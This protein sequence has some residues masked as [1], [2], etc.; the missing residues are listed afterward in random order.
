M[1]FLEKIKEEKLLEVE[2]KKNKV[3]IEKLKKEIKKGNHSFKKA[4]KKKGVSLIAEFKKASPSLGEINREASLKNYVSLYDKYADCISILTDEKYF[5]GKL[6]FLSEAKK[7]TKKPILRKD[8]I[9]DEYQIYESR[10]CNADAVLLIAEMLSK[11][12]IDA[13]LGVCK[14]LGMDALVECHDAKN[15]EKALSSGAEIIG[16]N[17]RNLKTMKEDFE[18][19]ERLLKKIPKAKR[20]KLIIVSESAIDTVG[21]INSLKE[22]ADAVL[23]GSAIMSCA[24]PEIKLKELNGKTL[25]KI[26]GVTN[27]KDAQDAVKL[28]ADMVGL[29]FYEKSPRFVDVKKAKEIADAIKGKALIVGVFVNESPDE[30]NKI[31]KNVS[32]DVLQFSGK[33]FPGYAR[34]FSLPIIKAIHIKDKNS[35][36]AAKNYH[37]PMILV[38]A[39]QK[40]LYG[41]TGK[42]INPKMIDVSKI[43]NKALVFSGGLNDKNVAGIVKKFRPFM[44]DTAS[45]VESEAGKK[46]FSKMKSF[47]S[48]VRGLNK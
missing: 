41:G 28:G 21:K 26:C 11:S 20:K 30:V 39:F 18:N 36:A 14:K 38:D 35:I 8:F 5:N 2:I 33:E 31:A 27:K 25:V 46:S 1:T 48:K 23:I 15:L 24:V 34:N 7:Y 12:Q 3:P 19:T 16:I 17:N 29:N 22:N 45:G 44:V 47:I 4:L 6:K 43:G 10:Y 9:V 40:G 32:L 13:F 37:V 42:S